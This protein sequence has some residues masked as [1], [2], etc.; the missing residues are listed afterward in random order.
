MIGSKQYHIAQY[1]KTVIP[2]QRRD[3][4]QGSSVQHRLRISEFWC[5]FTPGGAVYLQ[6]LIAALCYKLEGRGLDS[7]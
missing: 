4:K 2:L 3:L 1:E 6:Q 5:K 7:R